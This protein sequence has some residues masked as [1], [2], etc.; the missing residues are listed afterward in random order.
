MSQT[1]CHTQLWKYY[2]NTCAHTHTHAH[3]H[4]HTHMLIFQLSCYQKL[5][6]SK[7]L[8][9]CSEHYSK[10]I[11]SQFFDSA[12]FIPQCNSKI[13]Q[14]PHP[15]KISNN[16]SGRSCFLK[17]WFPQC[18]F[19][20]HNKKEM[21]TVN[22]QLHCSNYKWQLHASATKWPSSSCLCENYRTK[23]YTCSLHSAKYD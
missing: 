4:T 9:R 13:L 7:T 21:W 2:V 18:A 5:K 19:R 1:K 14:V 16:V 10:L 22:V 11:S 20:I 17:V 23:S 12:I 8:W 3:A 15:S 6:D